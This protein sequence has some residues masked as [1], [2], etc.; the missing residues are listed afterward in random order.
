MTREPQV[1][2]VERRDD[3]AG[4]GPQREHRER[5]AHRLVDVQEVEVALG[6]PAPHPHPADRPEGQP[7]PPE[8]LYFTGTARP[9]ASTYQGKG[10]VVVRRR[11]HA[12]VVPGADQVLGEVTDVEL[13]P[14]RHVERVGADDADR[15][16]AHSPRE[17][18][19][20][21]RDEVGDEHPLQHVPVLRVRADAVGERV[22]TACV[23][24]CDLL[25]SARPAV[26]RT[27]PWNRQTTPPAARD[28]GGSRS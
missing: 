11:E 25:R 27:S 5:R 21:D 18:G 12:H 1:R 10:R 19:R 23:I 7:A 9:A 13:D 26:A 3:R 20:R 6:E 15:M 16:A 17:L 28:P 4:R 8:P 24:A 2:G 22:R 14:A